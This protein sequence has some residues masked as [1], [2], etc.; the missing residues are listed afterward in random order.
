MFGTSGAGVVSV[1]NLWSRSCPYLELLE[2]ELSVFGGS[3]AEVVRV[4]NLWSWSLKAILA[5][6]ICNQSR[7]VKN[8]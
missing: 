4:W 2:P 1:R 6:D 7:Q 5:V 8:F 3:G